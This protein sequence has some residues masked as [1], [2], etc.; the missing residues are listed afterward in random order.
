MRS[1][2]TR[3]PRAAVRFELARTAAALAAGPWHALSF[4]LRRDAL[5]REIAS[6]LD[7]PAAIDAPPTAGAAPR[8]PRIF[9]SCA[10]PSGEL[11][12]V[13]LLRELRAL[14]PEAR[15]AGLGGR[16]L[17]AE[18]MEVLGDP[19]GRARMGFG[20]VLGAL[21][22]YVDLLER[23]ADHFMG[24]APAVAV[25]VDSPALHVPLGRIAR[26]YGIPVLHFVT[27]QH[28]AWAPW[29]ASGY[30]RAVDRA[31]TILPFEPA[32][33][34]RRGVPVAHVGHPLLDELV[35]VPSARASDASPTLAV[36]PGSRAGVIDLNLPWMLRAVAALRA[37]VPGLEAVV[38]QADGRH[39]GR[40][41]AH[42][43]EAE[44]QTWTRI[45]A[46]DLHASLSRARAAIS[47]SGTVLL[48]LL[49]H[50][51]PAV[52]IY[53]VATRRGMLLYRH[54]LLTPYF[55][56]VNLLAGREVLPEF[57]F[58]GRGP[59][60]EVVGVLRRCWDDGDY[61]RE[62]V[63]GLDLAAARLGPPGACRRAA[64]HVLDL[65]HGADT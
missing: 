51:L 26:A 16:A 54:A 5:R 47:V 24:A 32:W 18:G 38:I 13:N 53:R 35:R 60:D 21:P 64:L 50:R 8:A 45:E 42:V 4:M 63:R 43:A 25:L 58:R 11:H 7:H 1:T 14:A 3:D 15:V 37:R 31:L 52:C 48:D 41:A 22:F 46:G 2:A 56:S 17:A 57:C 33:F 28:W 40:I 62:M 12:A 44:A 61:R 55:A 23:C 19:V 59:L 6:D 36:L 49:H 39:D 27:P 9:L 20:G 10:E 65:A 34:A 29:R 30:A